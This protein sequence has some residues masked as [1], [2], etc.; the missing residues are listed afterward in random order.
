MARTVKIERMGIQNETSDK[1]YVVWSFPSTA[2]SAPSTGGGSTSIKVGSKVTVK[3]GSKW[4]NGAS[5]A[6]FVFGKQWNVVSVSG[7]RVV[8]GK[9]TDGA[10]NIMSPLKA[11]TLNVVT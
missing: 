10:Y 2:T 3:S 1:F 5:I 6:S 7:D 9:S 4:Y 11:S 8:L